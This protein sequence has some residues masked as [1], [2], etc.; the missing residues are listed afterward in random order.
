LWAQVRPLTKLTRY[1]SKDNYLFVLDDAL[2]LV[3][4]DKISSFVVFMRDQAQAI[5]KKLGA[6]CCK[7]HAAC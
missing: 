3:A 7:P 5:N 4:D 2:L 6:C 1:M